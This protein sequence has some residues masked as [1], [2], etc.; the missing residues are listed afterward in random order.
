MQKFTLIA[1]L[2]IAASALSTGAAGQNIYKCGGSYSQTPC[3][4]AVTL[5]VT[6]TRT[7]AQKKQTDMAASRDAKTADR[8]EKARELQQRK[9]TAANTPFWPSVGADTASNA[10]TTPVAKKK[11]KTDHFI[12]LIPGE[13]TTAKT[14]NKS[15]K[16]T[17]TSGF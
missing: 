2:F 7:P 10:E 14:T 1:M 9:D 3:P 12:A 15:P 6:D 17:A 16:K 11:T 8:M 4:G 5:D 13:K